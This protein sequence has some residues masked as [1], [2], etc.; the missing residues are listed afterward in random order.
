MLLAQAGQYLRD[1]VLAGEEANHDVLN[2]AFQ[3]GDDGIGAVD[4]GLLQHAQVAGIAVD[5]Q[6]AQLAG[7]RVAILGVLVEIGDLVAVIDQCRRQRAPQR[8][9]VDNEYIHGVSRG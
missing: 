3:Q 4:P 7:N 2:I 1:V 6:T 8:L 5:Y 9:L